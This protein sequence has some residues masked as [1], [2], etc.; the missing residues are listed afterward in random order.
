MN[1]FLVQCLYIRLVLINQVLT[2][3]LTRFRACHMWINLLCCVFS[4]VSMGK[5][6]HG[7]I[8]FWGKDIKKSFYNESLKIKICGFFM[9]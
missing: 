7:F 8:A 3:Q 4:T 9:L 6:L 2:N 5:N 1:V